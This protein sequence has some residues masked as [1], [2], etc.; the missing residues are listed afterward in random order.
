MEQGKDVLEL[1]NALT[2]IQRSYRSGHFVFTEGISM[3]Q[4]G[5]VNLIIYNSISW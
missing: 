3:L 1:L 2:S 4:T 5:T